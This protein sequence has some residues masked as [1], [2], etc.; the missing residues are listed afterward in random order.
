MFRLWLILAGA[1]FCVCAGTNTFAAGNGVA[2]DHIKPDIHNQPSLQRGL[3][4]YMNYCMGCHGLS[5]ARYERTAN[6][7]GIPIDLVETNLL[8]GKQKIGD[9]ME[10]AMPADKSAQWFGKTPPDL[11]LMARAKGAD[12]IYSYLR[13]FYRD[14]SRPFGVNNLV[15]PN[16]AMPHA[17]LDLQGLSECVPHQME[18]TDA[19]LPSA[20]A[21]LKMDAPGSL[22]AEEY[23]AAI[24][25][26]AN[27]MVYIAEPAALVRY[28]MGVYV[29]LALTLLLIFTWLLKREYWKDIQ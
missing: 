1:M 5:Y 13:A 8:S 21:E 4:I 2:L 29:M 24:Y 20:C 15:F 25:D 3:G 6:D 17:L 7:L 12:Y 10:T 16:T 11:T 22:S 28:R 27:F 18:S 26:L 19:P 23:D 9:L 14:D